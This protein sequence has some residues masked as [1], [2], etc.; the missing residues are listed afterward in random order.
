MIGALLALVCPRLAP[1]AALVARYDRLAAELRDA[2]GRGM[3]LLAQIGPVAREIDRRKL[4]PMTR[5]YW[6]SS[7]L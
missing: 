7:T 3:L 2:G 6:E 5:R 1:G 4:W